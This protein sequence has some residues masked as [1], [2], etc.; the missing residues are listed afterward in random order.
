MKE[1]ENEVKRGIELP[2]VKWIK[3]TTDMFD[4]PKIKYLRSLPD[5]DRL[6]LV[7]V[8][9]L[10]MAGRCNANGMLILSDTIPYSAEMIA[11]EFDFDLNTVRLA[12]KA[13]S[14]LNMI[15]LVDGVLAIPGW[16]EYQSAD[17]LKEL[18]EKDRERKRIARAKKKDDGTAEQIA[19]I[20]AYLN[21]VCGTNYRANSKQTKEK[22]HGRLSEGFTVDDFKAV[23]DSKAREWKGT[24]M[25]Q[26]LRPDTLFCPSKFESYLNYARKRMSMQ[27]AK[28]IEVAEPVET[29][30]ELTDEEWLNS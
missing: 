2:N 22:I 24:Q 13:F 4:N 18:R 15:M 25:E 21:E 1:N 10:T 8:A 29:E 9:V 5:G 11:N 28:R 23:V 19:E 27:R 7:W 12:L 30:P 14:D 17:R 16:S 20:V 6:L 26:Y 3:L